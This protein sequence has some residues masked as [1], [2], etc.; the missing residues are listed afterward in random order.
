[1]VEVNRVDR[2]VSDER[3]LLSVLERRGAGK[4][5]LSCEKIA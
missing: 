2:D 4:R 1:V 5:K 3:R